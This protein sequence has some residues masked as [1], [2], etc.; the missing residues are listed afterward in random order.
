VVHIVQVVQALQALQELQVLQVV[1]RVV[2]QVAVVQVA[3]VQLVHLERMQANLLSANQNLE[4]RCVMNSTICKHQNWVAQLFLTV[5]E[6]LKSVCAAV[7]HL[8]ILQ[9]RLMQIQ[10]R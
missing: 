5:M 4:K 10:Q 3:V 7:H 8:Q 1:H 2:H 6:R 9:R